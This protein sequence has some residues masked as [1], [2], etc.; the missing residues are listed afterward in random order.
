MEFMFSEATAFNQDLGWCLDD[1]MS[2]GSAFGDTQC[3]STFCGVSWGG[4]DIPSNGNVM[5]NGKIRIAVAAWVSDATAAE[6]TYGHISTWDTS[7]VTDMKCLFAAYDVACEDYYNSAASSFN[8]DISAWDTSGVTTMFR[9]F[10]WAASFNRP[11]G[12]WR[13]DNVRSMSVMFG[14]T[15]SMTFNQPLDKWRVDKVT[16]MRWMFEHNSAFNQDIGDWAVQSVTDMHAMFYRALGFNQDIGDWAVH[17]VADMEYMFMYASAFNQDLSGWAVHSV[18]YM[19]YMFYEAAAFD[20]DLGWCV[21][22]VVDLGNAFT[23]TPCASTSCGVKQVAGGCPPTPAPTPRPSTPTPTVTPRTSS[24]SGGSDSPIAVIAGAAAAVALLLAVGALWFYR[25]SKG[26]ETEPKDEVDSPPEPTLEP[27]E[28]PGEE[29]TVLSVALEAEEILAE[30]PAAAAKG[31]FSAFSAA[32][33]EG[34]PEWA[35]PA[36][37]AE[38]FAAA[39][40]PPPLADWEREM[41]AS[42]AAAEQGADFQMPSALE[43]ELEPEC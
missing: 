21:D 39:E 2:L 35:P 11:I 4:C 10:Y 25:R 15:A 17:S 1:D 9:M 38:D 37:E 12:G 41:N 28:Q 30:Q 7:G 20:Q 33:P 22:S 3:T 6:A 14:G 24:S 16:S 27:L 42:E 13:V 23:N 18:E 26:S 40:E 36:P 31:W 19:Q 43:G 29:A 8:E 32:E 34:E 5:A